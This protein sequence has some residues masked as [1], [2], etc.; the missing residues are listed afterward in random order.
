MGAGHG[1]GS[2][3]EGPTQDYRLQLLGPRALCVT[4]STGTVLEGHRYCTE[5]DV[6]EPAQLLCQLLLLLGFLVVTVGIVRIQMRGPPG[7]V[8]K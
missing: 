5:A 8:A 3:L 6:T 4:A 2:G 1:L 7:P